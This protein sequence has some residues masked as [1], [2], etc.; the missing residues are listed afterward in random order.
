[1]SAKVWTLDELLANTEPKLVRPDLGECLEWTGTV[2]MGYGRLSH[3]GASWAAHRLAYFLS[4]DG[5]PGRLMIL[6]RCDNKTCVNPCHLY[7]GTRHDNARDIRDRADGD[8]R[9][10]R[11][12]NEQVESMRRKRW[13]DN[14]PIMELASEFGVSETTVYNAT[15]GSSYPHAGGPTEPTA[16]YASPRGVKNKWARSKAVQA[17][18][19][20]T[21]IARLKACAGQARMTMSTFVWDAAMRRIEE[22]EKCA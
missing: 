22:M 3:E 11:M 13:E 1:M 18:F 2:T 17:R 19:R 6:H 14:V 5:I 4:R 20:P 9:S 7:A 15:I 16:K 8:G 12:T 10:R 21:D